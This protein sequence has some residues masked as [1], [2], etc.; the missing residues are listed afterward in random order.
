MVSFV[1]VSAFVS[2]HMSIYEELLFDGQCRLKGEE[3]DE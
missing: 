1:D 3:W 2:C